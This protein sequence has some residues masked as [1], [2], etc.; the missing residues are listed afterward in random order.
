MAHVADM[1]RSLAFYTTLGFEAENTYTVPG[2]PDPIWAYLESG[3]AHLMITRADAPVEPS[4]QAILFYLY[5]AEVETLHGRLTRDGL[6]PGPIE[7]PFYSPLGEFKLV[8]P[9]GYVIIVSH[10]EEVDEM[11]QPL[12][13]G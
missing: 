9:D 11:G 8:D 3:A 13:Q 6:K 2:E 7:K 5:A 10:V 12:A 1:R 4:A